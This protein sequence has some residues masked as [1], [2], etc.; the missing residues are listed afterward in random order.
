MQ[1][2][3]CHGLLFQLSWVETCDHFVEQGVRPRAVV[4]AE[5]ADVDIECYAADFR[6]GMNG[7]MRFGED[8]GAGHAGGRSAGINKW[9]KEATDHRQSVALAGIDTVVFQPARIEQALRRA[10]AVVEV[11][12]QV[13]AIHDLSILWRST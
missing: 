7:E 3:A 13:Q 12:D 11:G 8:N 9:V 4:A 2:A 10:A 6:P 1:L 5:V